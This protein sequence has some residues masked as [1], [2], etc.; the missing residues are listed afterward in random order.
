MFFLQ[1]SGKL[2]VEEYRLPEVK[3]NT[4]LYFDFLGAT[5]HGLPHIIHV[6][7]KGSS[8]GHALVYPCAKCG[9]TLPALA[10]LFALKV[11]VLA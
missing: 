4:P 3:A 11:H 1:E 6:N 9:L 7:S 10:T 8:V 5:H 2:V